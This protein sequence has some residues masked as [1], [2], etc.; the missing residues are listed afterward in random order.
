MISRFA[1]KT[2]LD[3]G[4]GDIH[5]FGCADTSVDPPNLPIG[6]ISFKNGEP[7]E[8]GSKIP[9]TIN[10]IEELEDCVNEGDVVCTFR[11]IESLDSVISQLNRVRDMMVERLGI[12]E[13][14]EEILPSLNIPENMIAFKWLYLFTSGNIKKTDFKFSQKL[15]NDIDSLAIE[16][17]TATNASDILNSINIRKLN[18][19]VMTGEYDIYDE[20]L[21]RENGI[22]IATLN[23]K[24]ISLLVVMSAMPMKVAC[25]FVLLMCDSIVKDYPVSR[26]LYDKNGVDHNAV[27]DLIDKVEDFI[28]YKENNNVGNL[29][30]FIKF[31]LLRDLE[32]AYG[33]PNINH[34][35]HTLSGDNNYKSLPDESKELLVI[36]GF[37][38]ENAKNLMSIF[39]EDRLNKLLVHYDCNVLESEILSFNN[40][41]REDIADKFVAILHS[42]LDQSITEKCKFVTDVIRSVNSN[43]DVCMYKD[44]KLNMDMV[45]DASYKLSHIIHILGIDQLNISILSRF[46]PERIIR[47]HIE[48]VPTMFYLLAED[49]EPNIEMKN[50]EGL[51]IEGVTISTI[52]DIMKKIPLND[53]NRILIDGHCEYKYYDTLTEYKISKEVICDKFIPILEE[54]ALLSLESKCIFI[55]NIIG[56]IVDVRNINLLYG[57]NLADGLNKDG[58]NTRVTSN[59]LPYIRREQRRDGIT[60]NEKNRE[61]LSYFI[62][63][64]ILKERFI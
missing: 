5:G 14:G 18:R 34:W 48:T 58:V 23:D 43:F 37:T 33:D 59:I 9:V 41:H 1:D 19:I 24:F 64:D 52:D 49:F 46:I 61:A 39:G 56:S 29:S 4:H 12:N 35:V 36:K 31:K 53:L 20:R 57:A 32:G 42:L 11:N 21:F 62:K 25:E 17:F 45:S 13:D 40:V 51:K 30:R 15:K 8:I 6:I 63:K 50:R 27:V 44:G 55:M 28:Y 22:D 38:N 2:I 3:F 54:I 16:G 10:S 7:M 26:K 60:I 47:T